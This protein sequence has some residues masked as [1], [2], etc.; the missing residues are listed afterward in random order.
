[1]N[2]NIFERIPQPY[3]GPRPF[4]RNLD[5]Q[6]RFFGREMEV[7]EIVSFIV[8][9]RVVLIYGKSGAGKT[10]IFNA[11]VIPTLERYG[12]TV[13]PISRV[14]ASIISDQLSSHISEYESDIT[15][16]YLF[17]AL[18]NLVSDVE[19]KLLKNKSLSEFLNEYFPIKQDKNNHDVPQIL[20]FDQ[21]EEFFNIF[22]RNWK[23]QR[24]DFFNHIGKALHDMT[25]LQIVFLIREDYL[26]QLEAY[27]NLLPEKFGP[28]FR[29]ERLGKDSALLAIK[30]PLKNLP[31][32]LIQ[33]Y[34][35]DIDKE[36][37]N[38]VHELM[39]IQIK[40]SSGKTL[41]IEGES[42]EPIQLQVVL[43]KWYEKITNP[44]SKLLKDDIYVSNVDIALEEF[45]E[46]AINDAIN[47]CKIKEKDIRKWC[48]E[49][50]I[51]S[52]GTKSNVHR[53]LDSIEGLKNDVI[54]ILEN[55]YFIK[56]YWHAGAKWYEL[57]QDRLVQSII[58]SNH[59]W[60]NSGKNKM[61][62]GFRK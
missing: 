32:D 59:K 56:G 14:Y 6:K 8:S 26:A 46:H 21:F 54:D 55:L 44:N 45:Y 47:K 15:N 43:K 38:I 19:P 9:H 33:N 57:S 42:I 1:M 39:K 37:N 23:E 51:T 31:K 49:K 16:I 10:S 3:I 7:E 2:N 29:L 60:K 52:S 34:K 62:F 20:I 48:E 30:G 58:S 27:N 5:D 4:E 61:K 12:F 53:S 13:L 36:I 22:P 24:E 11:Q 25:S 50:L 17:N 40:D 35:G 18:E 28:R 41:E